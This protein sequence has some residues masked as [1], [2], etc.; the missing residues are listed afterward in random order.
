MTSTARR[1]GDH[2]V[3]NGIKWFVSNAPVADVFV[4]FARTSERGSAQQQLSAFL[5][6]ADLPGV[7]KVRDFAKLGLRSTPMGAV[8]FSDVP[9]P[10][11]NL[12]G[13]EAP[14]TRSSAQPSSGNGHLSSPAM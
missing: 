8:Q 1:E 5:V 7:T 9:V 4:T 11:D 13:K 2:Y 10:A 14:A 3:L 12:I 6:T